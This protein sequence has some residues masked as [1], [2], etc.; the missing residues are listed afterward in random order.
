MGAHRAQ[1]RASGPVLGIFMLCGAIAVAAMLLLVQ[2]TVT[3][4]E[5]MPRNVT[6]PVITATSAVPRDVTPPVTSQGQGHGN[7]TVRDDTSPAHHAWHA[8]HLRHWHALHLRHL[9]VV[10]SH[11]G[12]TATSGVTSH[13]PAP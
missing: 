5:T 2:G 7:V 11:S 12:I 9:A 10:T 6:H 13:G 4:H 8:A 1:Y 3:S